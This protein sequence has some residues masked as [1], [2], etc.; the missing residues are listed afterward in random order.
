M[1]LFLH[2]IENNKDDI[3]TYIAEVEPS[4]TVDEILKLA[5][6]NCRKE[7]D[8][9]SLNLFKEFGANALERTVVT[10]TQFK[11]NDD[12]FIIYSGIKPVKVEKDLNE[13]FETITKYSFLDDDKK[14]K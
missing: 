9:K 13:N 11:D 10:E 5:V 8:A 3:D 12:V 1:R 6:I 2:F 4:F 7:L 14:V